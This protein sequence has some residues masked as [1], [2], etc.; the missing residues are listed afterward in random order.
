M[1]TFSFIFLLCYLTNGCILKTKLIADEKKYLNQLRYNLTIGDTLRIYYSTNSCCDYC[2]TNS[3]S[4]CNLKYEGKEV[5]SYYPEN[6]EG[7]DRQMAVLF[8]AKTTG[9]D[10]IRGKRI[11]ASQDCSDSV[12]SP[13]FY[14][15]EIK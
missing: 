3:E 9:T 14:I 5:I 13:D 8:V 10:T 7:C 12:P 2:I 4:I 11:A 15:V 1:K 6:C